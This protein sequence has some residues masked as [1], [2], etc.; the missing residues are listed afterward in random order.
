MCA[1]YLIR[2]RNCRCHRRR[3][4]IARWWR[5]CHHSHLLNWP[6]RKHSFTSIIC[7]E[8][9]SRL[10]Q[11][12]LRV[13]GCR[14]AMVQPIVEA[15]HAADTL[16]QQGPRGTR[17]TQSGSHP[18]KAADAD[19]PLACA[20]AG[21]NVAPPHASSAQQRI[22]KDQAGS[23]R[24]HRGLIRRVQLSHR[25]SSRQHSTDAARASSRGKLH[26]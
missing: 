9:A 8:R 24:R 11:H 22:R 10:H 3:N 26:W 13:Y 12:E 18:A 15:V 23:S 1:R 4:L 21:P 7:P 6:A 16:I 2:V 25:P 20:G 19:R 5:R 17:R 14:S